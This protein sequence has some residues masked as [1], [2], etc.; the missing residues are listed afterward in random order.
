MRS[1]LC[2]VAFALLPVFLAAATP[3]WKVDFGSGTNQLGISRPSGEAPEDPVY[4][5]LSVRVHGGALWV[6]DSV[7]GRLVCLP[8]GEKSVQ[9]LALPEAPANTLLEDFSLDIPRNRVWIADA[10]DGRI[11]CLDLTSGAEVAQCRLPSGELFAQVKQIEAAPD[12]SLLV[13]DVGKGSLL[14]FSQNGTFHS[15]CSIEPAGFALDGD[16]W[17]HD[18]VASPLHG[19]IWR[20]RDS[21]GQ[22]MRHVH[23]GLPDYQNPRIWGV[24]S[25][26]ALLVSVIPPGGFKGHLHLMTVL[27]TGAVARV[28]RF[29]PAPTMNRCVALAEDGSLWLVRADFR[30]ATAGCL[31]VEKI[32]REGGRQ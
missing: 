14:R 15:Q 28:R 5:P 25:S 12:G 21:Q 11:L 29:S 18:L 4:G 24:T 3:A 26:G 9:V 7:R 2:S 30:Q 20:V 31:T 27:P 8:S 32:G 1:A 6:A 19:L 10:A 22:E 13:W 23:V 16:A 17:V